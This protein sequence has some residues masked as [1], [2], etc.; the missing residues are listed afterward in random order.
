MDADGKIGKDLM[1]FRVKIDG[2]LDREIFETALVLHFF[3]CVDFV[4]TVSF[5]KFKN[6][7]ERFDFF[8]F[9]KFG[10]F[11]VGTDVVDT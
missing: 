1:K 7:E 2:F 9:I 4:D 8:G 5:V 10:A 6:R 3:E 11:Q